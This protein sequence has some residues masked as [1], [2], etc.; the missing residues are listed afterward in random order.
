MANKT[1]VS[2]I[3]S[4]QTGL[5]RFAAADAKMQNLLEDGRMTHIAKYADHGRVITLAKEELRHA[6]IRRKRKNCFRKA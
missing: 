6:G 3:T 4:R 1:V 5:R 2:I